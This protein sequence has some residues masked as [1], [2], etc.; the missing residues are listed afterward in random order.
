MAFLLKG[1]LIEYGSDFLGPLPNVVIFQFNPEQITRTL[2]VP[3]RPT[4]AG[5]RETS[6]A[7]EIPVEKLSLTAKFSA[8]DLLK[9]DNPLARAAGVGPFLAALEM[10]VLPKAALGGLLEAA[11]DAIGDAIRG[12]AGGDVT[13]PIPREK[14]PRLIFVWGLTRV[15]PVFV[16][17][18]VITETHYDYLLNPIAAEVQ[19]GLTVIIPDP[20]AD[21]PIAKG[22]DIYTAIAKES[23]A[24][25]NLA[26]TANQVVELIP[27]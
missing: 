8:A 17:S 27:I 20:C 10:M 15:L 23:L 13:Q 11:I 26:N 24:I 12:G 6:Q 18:M 16:H 14:Y 1:A 19:L 4:G 22:A 9:D 7:G 25:S 3:Q 5:G 21:D 2:E